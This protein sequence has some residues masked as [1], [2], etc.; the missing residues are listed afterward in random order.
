[1]ILMTLLLI[2]LDQGMPATLTMTLRMV[3]FF[4]KGQRRYPIAPGPEI[5]MAGIIA[6]QFA[7]QAA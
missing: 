5:T 7:I 6:D 1:M 2:P 3:S 4:V